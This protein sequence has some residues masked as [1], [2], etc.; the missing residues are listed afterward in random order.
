MALLAT[1]GH[2][3]MNLAAPWPMKYIVDNVVS[4][5]A[6]T[7]VLGRTISTVAADRGIPQAL[8]FGALLIILAALTGTFNFLRSYLEE[9]VLR[10]GVL[11]LRRDVL[12]HT[13]ALPMRFHDNSR[14]GETVNRINSDPEKVISGTLS[15]LVDIT[16]NS[17]RFV[18]VL[19]VITYTNPLLSLV[20]ILFSPL[21]LLAFIITRSKMRSANVTSRE[22]EGRLINSVM[23]T[24]S[25]IR[26]VKAFVGEQRELDRY[27]ER[28]VAH[29][30]AELRAKAWSELRGPI[31]NIIKATSLMICILIGVSQ[32]STGALTIGALIVY[33]SYLN[34]FYDP[35]EKF[36]RVA[37]ALQKA[38]ISAERL[39]G[40][41][42]QDPVDAAAGTLIAQAADVKRGSVSFGAVDFGYDIKRPLILDDISFKL[43][44]GQKLGVVGA[45]GAGKSTLV[46]LLL[47]FYEPLAGTILIDGYDTRCMS[48]SMLRQNVALVTQEPIL[49]AASIRDNIAYG[50][51]DATDEQVANAARLAHA[52]TFIQQLPDKYNTAIGERGATLSGGQRQRIALA[53]AILTDAPILILDEPTAALDAISERDVL[54]ALSEAARRR[55]TIVISHRLSAVRDSDMII[56]L[57]HGRIVERGSHDELVAHGGVYAGLWKTQFGISASEPEDVVAAMMRQASAT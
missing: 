6:H 19:A 57:E 7:D 47:R 1:V 40:I 26:V 33:V 11:H 13:Q 8:A 27:N 9:R 25:N 22:E 49:F 10:L 17:L 56:V 2:A 39:A 44:P 37:G 16:L 48:A 38:S 14:T 20:P 51:K 43:K 23:E 50:R 53:R 4:G 34:S 54:D 52:H 55:T 35:L 24:L 18:G 28:G 42:S 29:M 12:A 21:L 30:R 15:S 36:N 5:R 3:A 41:L 32:I 45:T 46:N 31:V